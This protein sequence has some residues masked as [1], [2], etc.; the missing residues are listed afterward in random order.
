MR[1]IRCQ[2]GDPQAQQVYAAIKRTHAKYGPVEKASAARV[3]ACYLSFGLK[4]FAFPIAGASVPLKVT[5]V[6]L[7]DTPWNGVVGKDLVERWGSYQQDRP[8]EST[9]LHRRISMVLEK[10]F[11]WNRSGRADTTMDPS[12]GLQP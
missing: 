5:G 2:P 10:R 12:F 6:M 11:A 4:L 9:A 3:S 7:I 8:P 1:S